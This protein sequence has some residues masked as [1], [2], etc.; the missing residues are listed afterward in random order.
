MNERSQKMPPKQAAFLIENHF[1]IVKLIHY[2]IVNI[3]P[4]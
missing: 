4:H 1:Q 3:R 2:Q